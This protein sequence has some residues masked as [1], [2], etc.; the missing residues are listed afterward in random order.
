MQKA[1]TLTRQTTMNAY[2]YHP[3]TQAREVLTQP[4]RF[5]M[6][7]MYVIPMLDF[8]LQP[9]LGKRITGATLEMT[10][11]NAMESQ[12]VAVSTVS[13]QWDPA[14]CNFYSAT[15]GTPWAN[16]RWF[17]DVIMSAGNS[18]YHREKVSYDEATRKVRIAIN[19]QIIAMMA[20]GESYGLAL[21]DAK[22]RF[23]GGPEQC[24]E[25]RMDFSADPALGDVP[26]LTVQYEACD[27]TAP[28]PVSALN[29]L[30]LPAKDLDF[31]SSVQLTW[32]PD[33]AYQPGS[34]YKLYYSDRTARVEDMQ[35]IEKFL[36]P[37]LSQGDASAVIEGLQPNT[38]YTF[39][40]VVQSG[41]ES[42]AP[43]YVTAQ[44]LS[45]L[46]M[47]KF[48]AS[49]LRHAREGRQAFAADG[50]SVGVTDDVTKVCPVSGEPY[51]FDMPGSGWT[52]GLYDGQRI[53]LRCA[54]GEKLGFQLPVS[55]AG[56]QANFSIKACGCLAEY[57]SFYRIWCLKCDDA[58]YPEVAVPVIDGAFAVPFAENKIPDQ[59]TLSIMVD[60]EL[61]EIMAAG[62]HEVSITIASGAASL[63][64][65]VRIEVA[66]FVLKPS[67][68]DLELNGYVYLPRCA[69]YED[70]DPIA[71]EVE[72]EYHRLAYRH[73]STVNILPYDQRGRI[74]PQAFAPKIGMVDGLMRVID[75]RE[76]DEHFA[77][78]I[79][80]SYALPVAGRKVPI[81]H[82]YLPLHENWPMPFEEYYKIA[83]P[84]LPYPDNVSAQVQL[85][86]NIYEDFKEGYREGLKS[87]LKDFIMHF[88]EKGWTNVSFQYFFNNKNFYRMKGALKGHKYGGGLATWLAHETIGDLG[89]GKSWWLLDEPHFIMDFDALAY[90]ASILR[91]ARAET[92][93]GDHVQFRADISCYFQAFNFLDGLLDINV[94]G[95][96]YAGK[97]EDMLRK[98]RR[99]YHEDYWPYGGWSPVNADNAS[100]AL[101]ILDVYLKGGQGIVPWYNFAIDVNYEIPDSCAAMYPGKRFGMDTALASLRLKAGRKA[102][103]LIRYLDLF[104]AATGYTDGQIRSYVSAFVTLKG[105]VEKRDDIDAGTASFSADRTGLENMRQDLLD[106]LTALGKL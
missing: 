88:E 64:V 92:G 18:V 86:G 22:S 82:M 46:H 87:V 15:D 41:G 7:V 47:P 75:W 85:S 101:W 89:E 8:N 34:R 73:N 17:T 25:H 104:K 44:T 93:A 13:Q 95:G 69:G 80:G 65:P 56:T 6:T 12:E 58:W 77:P 37:N 84:D 78:Y 30:A 9:L 26:V 51:A 1:F 38:P 100:A 2:M 35:L 79:D 5:S 19:P 61:P 63:T 45:A 52:S 48:T 96:T 76:W 62:T 67:T 33:D 32:K 68:F 90:Y 103:E 53:V 66:D 72:R 28:V 99:L 3:S 42:S 71:A 27:A 55:I 36:T 91:E 20:S 70:D 43:R 81:T 57:V 11:L 83:V 16:F 60:F 97:R 40:V 98:R 54:K 4:D 14:H 102:L 105:E 29:A 23:Y 94:V 74:Q 39:A 49:S 24:D 106:R 31:G 50:F 21:V 59:K 10:A